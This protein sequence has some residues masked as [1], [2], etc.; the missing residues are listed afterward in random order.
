MY[1]LSTDFLSM[2]AIV[3]GLAALL[4][5]LQPAAALCER[6]YAHNTQWKV[7]RGLLFGF[8]AGYLTTLVL[9]SLVHVTDAIKVSS[10]VILSAGGL[11]VW[12]VLK[13]SLKTVL[14]SQELEAKNE[15]AALH[16]TLTLL[17]NERMLSKKCASQCSDTNSATLIS[18]TIQKFQQIFNVLG[19]ERGNKLL[20]DIAER[21]KTTIPTTC[22]LYDLGGCNFVVLVLC[23]ESESQVVE[24][25][26]NAMTDPFIIQESSVQLDCHLGIARC[27][28]HGNSV[29]ALLSHANMAANQARKLSLPFCEYNDELGQQ[30]EERLQISERLRQAITNNELELHYQ[31]IFA[32]TSGWIQSVEALV[33]WPQQDGS[34]ISPEVFIPIAEQERTIHLLTQW[35]IENSFQQLSTW[36]EAGID[37][38]MN[39]NLSSHDLT[40][41]EFIE[42]LENCRQKWQ[43]QSDK[44]V[45][46]LTES[47]VMTDFN[48]A[49]C[50]L[51]E[52]EALGY[53]LAIDDFGTGYSSMSRLKNLPI[54]HIKI[55]REFIMNLHGNQQNNSIVSAA[56]SIARAF[57]CSITAEGVE[58]IEVANELVELG[59][60]YLQGYHF[61]RPLSSQAATEALLDNRRDHLP[62]D[63]A[64]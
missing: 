27:P 36:L 26:T 52:L 23:K 1:L 33:R 38:H 47:A 63:K 51:N 62:L 20:V 41:N 29:D 30:Q 46:E 58:S 55:D 21:I 40:H 43:L 53:R 9:F 57:G 32:G 61:S 48:K 34:Y 35:V 12:M 7:L 10:A 3:C 11:F 13:L 6:S 17:P 42:F 4:V 49:L 28:E 64:A 5:S 16:N 44:L 24:Q 22:S 8:V 45:L 50:V 15:F 59:C 60:D 19:Y 56:N 14:F 39:V 25:I 31:P 2:A 37:L 54:N 18:I